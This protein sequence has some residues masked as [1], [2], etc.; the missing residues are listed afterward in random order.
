MR[1]PERRSRRQEHVWDRPGWQARWGP[2]EKSVTKSDR[3]RRNPYQPALDKARRELQALDPF[4]AALRCGGEPLKGARGPGA[5]L[6]Y[7]G[8]ALEV[9]WE[10]G[11]VRGAAGSA[12]STEV[13]LVVLHYLLT[14]DGAPQA[15]RWLSFRELPDGRVYD[16][17]FRRRSCL[18][19]AMAFGESLDSFR[20]AGE[21][22]GGQ[23]LTYGDASFMFQVLPRVRVA[24]ILHV[25]DDEF[26]AEASVLFDAS[27][28]HYLPIED[29]AALGGL[30]A[31][32]LIR[33]KARGAA[34]GQGAG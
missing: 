6:T 9:R 34:A 5:S 13:T 23:P 22:L 20:T 4:V 14:A 19:L 15:D 7:W 32:E 31:L 2:R 1:G 29:V 25:R 18:P 17:A 26:P 21:S 33:A 12:L 27:V 11:E 28:R 30:V 3:A 8:R 16:A 10:T 24:T